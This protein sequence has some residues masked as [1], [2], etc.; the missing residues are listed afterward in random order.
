MWVFKS[1]RPSTRPP[2]SPRG[3]SGGPGTLKN[4]YFRASGV[5]P[6]DS[7]RRE[8]QKAIGEMKIG[9]FFDF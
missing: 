1:S 7:S 3:G 8:L 6:I 4:P 9:D 5:S 2:L